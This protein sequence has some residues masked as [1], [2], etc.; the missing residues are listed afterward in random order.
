MSEKNSFT[1]G[2][3]I[4]LL[5][6]EFDSNQIDK[7][8]KLLD[9]RGLELVVSRSKTYRDDYPNYAPHAKG[10]LLQ[11]G[12]QLGEE[13]INGLTVCEIIA[14][15]GIGINDLDVAAATKQGIIT[16][17]V[18]DFC[19]EDVSDHVL[20]IILGLNRRLPECQAMTRSGMWQAIDIWPIRRL[21][22][23]VLGVVGFGKIGKAVARKANCFGMRVVAHDPYC[24]E[25]EMKEQNI[26]SLDFNQLIKSSDF[27]S[28][29]VPL[30]KATYHLIDTD[31]FGS[32]KATAYLV[33]TCRGDVVDESALID[34]LKTNRIAG[35]GLDVLSKEPPDPE[36]PLLKLPNVL[37][38]PHSAFISEEALTDLALI[39]TQAV[40]DK[41]EEKI[42]KNI[43]NPEVLKV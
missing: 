41:L 16:T 25:S 37:I 36:N 33:N 7:I 8:R 3:L 30:T 5:D 40:F 27:I 11:V 28:L 35:A 20:A 29:H 12:F 31:K 34:A 39:S 15:T 32:M 14:V 1:E 4:W 17:N 6:D 42:P 23:Q 19:I 26:E 38:S 18:P 24:D 43:I 2:N 10:I 13:D 21:K 9:D 22:G